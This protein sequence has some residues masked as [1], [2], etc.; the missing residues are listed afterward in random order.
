MPS[1]Q[2]IS[3]TERLLKLIRSDG[4]PSGG[5]T[6]GA[7]DAS[8]SGKAG[9]G[10]ARGF[11]AKRSV[12][13][14]VDIGLDELRL[15]KVRQ[16]SS[17]Q[18]ELLDC[19]KVFVESGVSW[20][21]PG[22]A[23]FLRAEIEKFC[24]PG[25]DYSIWSMIR[26][27]RVDVESLRIPKVGKKQLENAVFWTAKKNTVFDEKE[28]ILDFEVQGEV[29]EEGVTRLSVVICTAPKR[30]VEEMKDLF[31]D[32]GFPLAGLT[33]A[34][35]ALQNFFR[36]GWMSLPDRTATLYIG[37]DSSRIDVFSKG[38]LVMTRG[39]RAGINSMAESLLEEHSTASVPG[40]K[41]G[42][43]SGGGFDLGQTPDPM[44]IED[45]KDLV[46]SLGFD[47]PPPYGEADR[48]GLGKEEIFAMINPALERL[49]R[50]VERTLEHYTVILGN[51]GI[52]FVYV[53]SDAGVYRPVV[54]YVGGQLKLE[55]DVLDPLAPENPF[56]GPLTANT[57][58]SQRAS[59]TSALGL[60]LSSLPRTPN[61]IFT[62]SDKEKSARIRRVNRVIISAF[63]AAV[64]VFIGLF[65]WMGDT[66]DRKAA[67]LER[68]DRQL[69][70]DT[71][72]IEEAA[73]TMVSEIKDNRLVL[74]RFAE[75]YFGV[76]VIGELA[77]LT[78][79]DVHLLAVKATMRKG[80]GAEARKIA[81]GLTINGVVTG[82]P[83]FL[84][85]VLAK[86]VLD[87]RNSRMFR[88]VTI[89]KHA[90]EAFHAG[91]ALHFSIAIDFA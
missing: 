7:A 60:A 1:Q 13:V 8:S 88:K 35:F 64:V 51:E 21:T 11:L 67:A 82:D 62:H 71:Q 14:G 83:G 57:S 37:D 29:V 5:S 81:E 3:S 9:R 25:K 34:P 56:S 45:A 78:P 84:E 49:V 4:A 2:D 79:Q 28:T 22:F 20:G 91:E 17:G 43:I 90:R 10:D 70:R 6:P 40:E 69:Q 55:S 30:E 19:R 65:F 86:Y 72:V 54:E 39:I 41:W 44:T 87:L 32:I 48:F 74:Q 75:R 33:V 59:L 47:S 12:S 18:Y 52:D 76:A 89:D 15:V 23:G 46:F 85:S 38:N 53:F 26:S 36:V 50:Q 66:V 27:D 24:G 80:A 77:K 61:L 31:D 16:P 58:T 63:A 73:R 42:E 68:L